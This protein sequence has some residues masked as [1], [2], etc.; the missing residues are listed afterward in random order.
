VTRALDEL[1][2]ELAADGG[3]FGAQ[4]RAALKRSE[5]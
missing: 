2:D 5:W 1:A 4:A 3:E